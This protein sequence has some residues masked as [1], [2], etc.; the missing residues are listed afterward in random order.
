MCYTPNLWEL[1]NEYTE[2]IRA[3]SLELPVIGWRGIFPETNFRKTPPVKKPAALIVILLSSLACTLPFENMP[4]ESDNAEPTAAVATLI[5]EDTP[6]ETQRP[7]PNGSS[8]V[9]QTVIDAPIANDEGGPVVV[10]GRVSYTNPFFTA[11]VANPLIILEDQAGFIDR[12]ENFIFPVQSQ[13][14]G[15]ITSDF[16]QSPFSYSLALPIAPQ[17]SLRDVDNDGLDDTGVMVFAVAYWN[18]TWGDPYL[19]E[20]DLGGGGWST[21]YASTRTF[22]DVDPELD[23]EIAGGK[24]LVYAPNGGQE[25]PSD[26]GPDE[27]LFTG[28][29]PVYAI[30]EGWTVVDLDTSPF[31]FDRSREVEFQLYEPENSALVDFSA[32]SYTDAFDAMV[33]K[34]SNEYAF[35]ENKNIDWDALSAEYRPRFEEADA[36][37]SEDLYAEALRDFLYEIPDGHIAFQFLPSLF[38]QYQNGISGGVGLAVG[39]L[40]DGTVIATTVV[41]GMPADEAGIAIG[42]EIV[43][44]NGEPISDALANQILWLGPFSTQHVERLNQLRQRTRVPVGRDV[45]VEY[46]PANGDAPREVT[47]IGIAEQESWF[48]GP[49]TSDA[50]GF[51]LPVQYDVLP[52]GYVYAEITS[53]FD[54]DLLTIQLWERLIGDLNENDVPGLILDMRENGG[55]SGFLADQMA[56]YFFDEEL[57]LGNTGYY[58]ETLDAFYFDEEDVDTFILPDESLRYDGDVVIIVGPNCA[59]ACEFF[60][61]NMTVQDRATV[62]G[63]F[64]T[65]GLGGSVE[66]FLM[67]PGLTVRFTIGQAVDQNGNIHIEGI[68]VVP[69]VT[70]PVTEEALIGD[71]DVLLEEAYQLLLEP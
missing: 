32:L 12:D 59:S 20:R 28:D 18:N 60:S 42:A 57:E 1:Y 51:E 49:F 64:P 53:F 17:G 22:D 34:M 27:L 11:G 40:S 43:S 5:P 15:Q 48:A 63:H 55:G 24:L 7:E 2:I 66:D 9:D 67:P 62:I 41:E 45:E 56:A 69:D 25:F 70:I 36:S 10:K 26:F 38:Q 33:E 30:P 19:E 6:E 47:L 44:W 13:T 39:E 52:G 14:L 31:T 35:T 21:A 61:Y 71:R 65:A 46:I 29:E 54:N 3:S 68:G 50:T 4:L 23:K 16:F 58:D 8:S 37:N